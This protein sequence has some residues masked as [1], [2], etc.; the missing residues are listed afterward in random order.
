MKDMSIITNKTIVL[1]GASSGIGYELLKRFA[2]GERGNTILA[3]ALDAEEK[4]ADFAPN[5][6]PFNADIGSEAGVESIFQRA[7]AMFEMIDIFYN[8]AGFP[9]IENYTYLNWQRLQHIFDVNTLAPIYMYPRYLQHLNGR[10][11]HLCYTISV[12]AKLALPGYA[13]YTGSKFGLHGFQ[14]AIRLEMPENLKITCLYPVA[15]ETNFFSAGSDGVPVQ[16]PWPLQTPEYIADCMIKGMVR[17]K[18]EVYPPVWTMAWPWM[19]NFAFARNLFWAR[20]G[21]KM[22]YNFAVLAREK[23]VQK[24]G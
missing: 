24:K 14:Q 4:L 9:Y 18:Q 2:A 5:V 19:N 20:E 11:G 23:E 15:T 6:V 8:N 1:T 22:K 16:K 10:P 12:I 21:K 3:V 17:G 13:L 7:E